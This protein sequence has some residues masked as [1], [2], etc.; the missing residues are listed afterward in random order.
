MAKQRELGTYQMLW[1]CEYCGTTKLL[2]LDHRHCPGCGT[3]QDPDRRYFPGD[4]DKVAV[5]DHQFVGADWQCASCDSPNATGADFCVNCGAGKEGGQA[6]GRRAD[7]AA[8]EGAA[9]EQDTVKQATQEA[10]A[11]RHADREAEQ[12]EYEARR[13]AAGGRPAKGQGGGKGKILLM[14][15]L[16]AVVLVILLLFWKKSATV[17][18]SGHTWTRAVDI[19]RFQANEASAWCDEM[20][21]AAYSVTQR[22]EKRGTERVED[23][24]TCQ[25]VQQDQGDGTF[26]E[27]EECS[28][29][30]RDVDVFDQKCYFRIDSWTVIRT[31]TA[32]GASLAETPHWPDPRLART[33]LGLG[34][35]REGQRS[36]TYTVSFRHDDGETDTCTFDEARWR[37]FTVGQ[38][39]DVKVGGLTGG[40]AC[41]SL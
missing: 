38:Q 3:P 7:R 18:V 8:A 34:A 30:Y 37:S 20:P 27:I 21:R 14:I 16:A 11:R 19:E 12:A 40:L 9:F 4:E 35:E 1:D 6:V 2:A 36:E 26:K 41:G 39:L 29:T 23:G 25:T 5:E 32:S 17:T 22:R 15:G 13:A 31:E 33:G 10:K 28:P 24:E